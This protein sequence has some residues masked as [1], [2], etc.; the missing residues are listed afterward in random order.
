MRRTA[1]ILVLATSTLCATTSAVAVR[2]YVLTD[3]GNL[4][5]AAGYNA[6]GINS[7]GQVVGSAFGGTFGGVD[8]PG[9]AFL[10]SP[11]T[12]NGTTGQMYEF[13]PQSAPNT[14]RA[15]HAI[16]DLGQVVGY[17]NGSYPS[18]LS[19][20]PF[21]WTPSTPNGNSGTMVDLGTLPGQ[22]AALPQGINSVG[23]VVGLGDED[24]S[25]FL[26]NPSNPNGSAGA[27]FDLGHL[28]GGHNSGATAINDVGQ[29]VG[30][31]WPRSFLWTP[32]TPNG[33]TG[34]MIDLGDL[35]GGADISLAS[36][37]N[38]R[39][40]VVGFSDTETRDRAFLWT[41]DTANGSTGSMINL[42]A[43][44]GMNQSRAEAINSLGQ[45]IG[46]SFGNVDE[47]ASI[48]LWT[49]DVPNG[50]TGT[51][52]DLKTFFP[53]QTVTGWTSLAVTDINDR[54]QIS[55]HGR[56]DADGPRGARFVER[57]FLLTPV[58]EPMCQGYLIWYIGLSVLPIRR[59]AIGRRSRRRRPGRI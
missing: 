31:T 2:P 48:F 39:G 57:A 20:Q 53:P 14:P 1:L 6:W 23:Q 55:G 4:P 59:L 11:N 19:R 29:I 46:R 27:M 36:D 52:I 8:Y 15:A 49:P 12:P 50:T 47:P 30:H 7:S 38:S 9:R 18:N 3:L 32:T 25:T 5:R 41:P 34:S 13:G 37:I 17:R 56:F 26:W 22:T 44:P 24:V 28:G 10:W 35:P 51:M 54:G 21:L 42:G 40:H 45:V 43:L 33:N 58:P 16:N